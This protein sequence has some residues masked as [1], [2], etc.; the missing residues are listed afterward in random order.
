M[1]R[2]EIETIPELVKSGKMN[3]EQVAKELVVFIMRNKPMFGLQKYDEDFI[4]DFIIQFLVR[5]PD[6]LAEYDITKGG[7]MSYLFCM[8]KNI[9]TSLNKKAALNSRIEYHNVSESIANYQ[10]KVDAYQNINYEEFERPKVP[11]TYK[12]VSYKDFQIACKTDSYHIKRIISS[13]ESAFE[14]DIKKKLK[15]YSPKMIQN[16]V[17]VLALKSSYYITDDQIEKISK[18]LNIDKTS[19]HEIIQELKTLMDSRISNKEKIEIRRNRA[20]YNHKTMRDQIK[21]NELNSSEPQYENLKL[22]RKYEK[23]TR[24]WKTL[25]HQLEEGKILIRPTTKLIAKVLGISSRQVTYYQTTA[26]KLGIKIDKV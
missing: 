12:P 17:I 4:S 9:I 7:F 23:N 25:N 5:G 16:I 26:R 10:N 24:S 13:E 15:G 20:Y 6:A 1:T 21:W 18:L 2:D 19:I 22:N 14:A 11:Y 8:I 3:W